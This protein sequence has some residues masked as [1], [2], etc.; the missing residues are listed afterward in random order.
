MVCPNCG[1]QVEDGVQFCPSCGG[2]VNAQ[3]QMVQGAPVAGLPKNGKATTAFVCGIIGFLCCTFVSI[4]ALICG[5]LGVLDAKN[6]KVDKKNV[7]MAWVGIV[8]GVLGLI[9]M[10][11]NIIGVISGS[12][13]IYNEI[14]NQING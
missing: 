5:I 10:V 9:V 7:W 14:M 8:L 4:P 6:G 13:D 3:P 1:N 12:N 2:A 11:I